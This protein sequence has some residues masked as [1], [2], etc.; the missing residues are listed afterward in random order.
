MKSFLNYTSETVLEL[1]DDE[2][3]EL[4]E[5]SL[6]TAKPALALAFAFAFS[7]SKQVRQ[8]LQNVKST[9]DISEK[10][11]ELSDAFAL[12][13]SKMNAIY[14]MLLFISKKI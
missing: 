7:K 10:I 14:T 12:T 11:D 2:R 4:N 9:E 1:P 13:D 3:K 6:R 5:I 8:K